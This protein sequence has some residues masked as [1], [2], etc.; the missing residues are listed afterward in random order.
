MLGVSNSCNCSWY[1]QFII[2]PDLI[3]CIKVI[4]RDTDKMRI[5]EF[6]CIGNLTII[7]SDN[8]LLPGWRQA[9]IWT[10]AEM[11][12]IGHLATNFSKIVIE[13]HASH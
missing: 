9:M 1:F 12:L 10:N 8:S 2:W 4:Y 7:G 6:L 11:L 5:K 13:I 3:D